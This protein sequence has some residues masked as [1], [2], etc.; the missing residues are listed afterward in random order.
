MME[1]D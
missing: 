1:I